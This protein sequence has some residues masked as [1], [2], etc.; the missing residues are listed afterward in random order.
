MLLHGLHATERFKYDEERGDQT[1]LVELMTD[2]NFSMLALGGLV[3]TKQ[4]LKGGCSLLV[5]RSYRQAVG[6]DC[7]SVRRD[8]HCNRRRNRL[9]NSAK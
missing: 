6:I 7:H 1:V 8:M 2:L 3:C 4:R 9:C 5:G